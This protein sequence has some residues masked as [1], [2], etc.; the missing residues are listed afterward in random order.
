MFKTCLFSAL[1]LAVGCGSGTK[2]ETAKPTPLV[3][4]PAPAT[5]TPTTPTPVVKTPTT[6]SKV[7]CVVGKLMP[8]R[9]GGKVK[10]AELSYPKYSNEGYKMDKF[11]ASFEINQETF[12][13]IRSVKGDLWLKKTAEQTLWS[14]VADPEKDCPAKPGR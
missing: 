1:L 6:D 2:D 10:R 5:P 7:I 8:A 4:K 14:H 13:A 12:D 11:G 9:K 3:A